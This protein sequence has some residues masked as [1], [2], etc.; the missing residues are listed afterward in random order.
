MHRVSIFFVCI[1]MYCTR[2]NIKSTLTYNILL[3]TLVE[4]MYVYDVYK[5]YSTT[6]STLV[7]V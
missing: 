7:S 4:C 2:H 6:R 3:S 5:K 1:I